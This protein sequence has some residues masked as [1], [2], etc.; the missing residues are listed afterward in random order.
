MP[1]VSNTFPYDTSP[2][3]WLCLR[4]NAGEHL[5]GLSG[6]DDSPSPLG[7][8]DLTGVPVPELGHAA[9]VW[10]SETPG[11]HVCPRP[12]PGSARTLQAPILHTSTLK[13]GCNLSIT[14]CL[15]V[16]WPGLVWKRGRVR[17]ACPSWLLFSN[18]LLC[19]T[20]EPVKRED[21]QTSSHQLSPVRP[22]A[23]HLWTTDSHVSRPALSGAGGGTQLVSEGGSSW[24]LAQLTSPQHGLAHPWYPARK[25]TMSVYTLNLRVFWPLAACLASA[26]LLLFHFVL[27]GSEQRDDGCPDAGPGAVLLVKSL[28][29]L[30]FCYIIVK[31]CSVQGGRAGRRPRRTAESG[32]GRAAPPKREMLEEHFE[33]HVRLSPHV[34][35]HSKAHVAKLVGELVRVGRADVPPESSLAFRGDFVQIGSSY[36]EHKVGSP[37]CFDILV[38]LR[39]PRGLKLE[40]RSPAAGPGGGA[41]LVTLDTPRRTEWTRRHRGFAEGFLRSHGVADSC[42]LSPDSVLRWFYAASQRCLA[43]VRFPFEERCSLSLSLGEGQRVH[44][45]LAPR[46]DY[47]CCHISMGVRLIPALPLGDSAY[48]VPASGAR[49]GEDLW[50]AYFPRQE[51]RLL[52]WLKGRLP[53]SSCHLKCLQLL[54]EVR[55]LGGQALDQQAGAEWRGVL[56]SYSLKTAWLRLLLST[57]PEVWEER[58][59]VGRLEDLLRCLRESLQNRALLH[60]L[61]GGDS[62]LLPDSLALPM[63]KLAEEPMPSNLWV[64]FSPASLDLVSARLAY[65]WAHL[66]RLIRLGRPQRSA[67]GHGRHCKHVDA[68]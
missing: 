53:P 39:L 15:R 38:P 20:D 50:T 28:L 11:R 5:A 1:A 64:E 44:L 8:H 60:L 62:G 54:K 35:G 52:G 46:S 10:S 43:T 25:M 58:H 4:P 59:L 2:R 68:K 7:S 9:S 56:S 27:R 12:A 61:L 14:W 13:T 48:L 30:A 24:R 66:P 45:R 63:P 19:R 23:R 55:D 29:A 33:K 37:D 42:R 16:M 21:F 34:L 57:P 18:W 17:C 41:P 31:C 47:V 36:E 49:K 26:L 65:S 40:P 6:G 3:V 32:V 67:L 51:Q 22:Y